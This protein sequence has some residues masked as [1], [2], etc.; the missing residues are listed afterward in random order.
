[1][2]DFVP[3]SRGPP[4]LFSEQPKYSRIYL[5]KGEDRKGEDFC[6]SVHVMSRAVLSG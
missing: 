6:Y 4:C 5:I 1:M 2:Y 3:H